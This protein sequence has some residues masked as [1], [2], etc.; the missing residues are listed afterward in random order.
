MTQTSLRSGMLA[1]AL[2]GLAL[3]AFAALPAEAQ[4]HQNAP[5]SRAPVFTTPEGADTSTD[6]WE[7]MLQPA[8][9]DVLNTQ[10]LAASDAAQARLT[11]S[12]TFHQA[13]TTLESFFNLGPSYAYTVILGE[14]DAL[15][16]SYGMLYKLSTGP[17]PFFDPSTVS[18]FDMPTL[19]AFNLSPSG[20]TVAI[21]VGDAGREIAEVYFVDLKTGRRRRSTA[22][23]VVI[24]GD[25]GF[26]WIDEST[27]M[28][29]KAGSTDLVNGDPSVGAEWTLYDINTGR[30]GAA[31]F[32][33]G[34]QGVET[35]FGDWFGVWV[36]AGGDYAMGY[37]WRGNFIDTYFTDIEA[38]RAGDPVWTEVAG[39]MSVSDIEIWNDHFIITGVDEA[40]RS[41]LYA[42]PVSGGRRLLIARA[43]GNESFLYTASMGDVAFVAA[44]RG[45]HHVL[46][47]MQDG[48]LEL[49]EIELPFEGEIDFQSMYEITGSGGSVTFDMSAP[50]RPWRLVRLD[51]SG[52]AYEYYMP[53]LGTVEDPRL[54]DGITHRLDHVTSA[55][56]ARVPMSIIMPEDAGADGTHP[57]LIHAYGSY[58]ETTMAGWNPTA[59]TWVRMG[60]VYAECHVRGS[61]F[62]GPAWHAGGSGADKSRSHADM[63][64]CGEHLVEL[65]LAEPGDIAAMGASAGGL[66]AGPV[67]INR[68]D[69]FGAA[70]VEFGVVNPLRGLDGPNG[71]T[72]ID[73]FG[74]P[75]L[76]ADA[77][78]MASADSVEL[79][80]TAEAL[81]DMFL[82]VGFQDSRVPHWMSAR[83]AAVMEERALGNDI[84]IHANADAGH[85]CGYYAEDQREAIAMQFAWLMDRLDR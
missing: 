48:R 78:L 21:A 68:P 12:A 44:R 73:E 13:M 67:S 69:L 16:L 27:G 31:V 1:A 39:D 80:R 38:L 74:D 63:I 59:L 6:P 84:V 40:G 62:Y 76:P 49:N 30:E 60:G 14:D 75:S 81:P 28:F 53:Y 51:R 55:D 79:A 24:G 41:N 71:A 47:R 32:H 11:R 72:Q 20:R 61:G 2:S 56:G 35:E 65:G 66:V 82:C 25:T 70:I 85:S 64:A 7:W 58:G 83:L 15:Y 26:V 29:R 46:Y 52:P 57:A 33:E 4:S 18:N 10:M 5:A 8:F 22:G 36:P 42:E 19:E 45:D 17:A 9:R 43:D 77:V 34:S 50:D 3:C 37:L 23:P 54:L